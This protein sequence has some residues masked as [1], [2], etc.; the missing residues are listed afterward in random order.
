MRT[1]TGSRYRWAR[2]ARPLALGAFLF[3]TSVG[4]SPYKQAGN[5][6]FTNG[7]VGGVVGGVVGGALGQALQQQQYY[8]QQQQQQ[9]YQQQQQ[10]LLQQQ[11]YYQQQQQQQYYQQQQNAAQEEERQRYLAKKK[12]Q[13]DKSKQQQQDQAKLT[14][15][16]GGGS[17]TGPIAITMKRANGILWVPAQ[18]NKAVAINF[19]VDSGAADVTIPKDVFRTLIRTGTLSEKDMIGSGKFGT[20]DGS[21]VEGLRFKLASLQ[22]GDQILTDVVASVIPKS[23]DAS[24]PLLGQSFLSRFQSWSIDNNSGTLNLSPQGTAPSAAPP[25]TQVAASGAT[26]AGSQAQPQPINATSGTA[27]APAVA[28]PKPAPNGPA[29]TEQAKQENA[30]SASLSTKDAGVT[31]S[32]PPNTAYNDARRSLMALGYEPAPLPDAEKCD[33]NTD[34][35]CFPEREACT[36][37]NGTQCDFFWKRGERLIKVTTTAVPPTVAAVGCQANCQ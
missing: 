19:I 34:K 21:E 9:Y 36:T 2:T 33:R 16:T 1:F 11:Q 17:G 27:P 28:P 4:L 3:A 20:A 10:Q 22:V 26:T 18:I 14:P 29:N 12:A 6:G 13:Q 30:S 7:F 25:P 32:F 8:Q 31:P 15:P 5:N 24:Q 35:T 37:D 23:S